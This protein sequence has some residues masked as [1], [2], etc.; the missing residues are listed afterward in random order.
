MCINVYCAY[1]QGTKMTRDR[2]TGVT[3]LG[4]GERMKVCQVHPNEEAQTL[5]DSMGERRAARPSAVHPYPFTSMHA[6]SACAHEPH[7]Y[8]KIALEV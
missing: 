1:A 3:F 6:R 7:I 8:T 5:A 4:G 2:V